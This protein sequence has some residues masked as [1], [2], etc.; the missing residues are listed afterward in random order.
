MPTPAETPLVAVYRVGAFNLETASVAQRRRARVQWGGILNRLTHPI[1]II[2][3]GRPMTTLPVVEG[4]RSHPVRAAR[5]LGAWFET[6]LTTNN[7]VD[8][9]RLLVVTRRRREGAAVPNIVRDLGDRA[10]EARALN[11]LS[12]VL[13][14]LGDLPAARARTE[15]SLAI[16]R[17]LGDQH[18]IAMS[19]INLGA[20]A[21][22]QRDY[23]RARGYLGE[24]LSIKR[25]LGDTWGLAI[26]LRNLANVAF[27]QGDVDE[28]QASL[29][30]CLTLSQRLGVP[31][32]VASCFVGLAAIAG[33]RR[34]YQ[35][36]ARLLGAAEALREIRGTPVAV[37]ER[38]RYDRDVATAR[39]HLDPAPFEA[40]W[41]EGR[42]LAVEAAVEYALSGDEK[43]DAPPRAKPGPLSAREQEVARLI[44]RGLTN[45]EIADELVI[46][47]STVER[48]VLHIFTKLRVTNR[49]QIAAWVTGQSQA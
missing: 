37:E 28:A 6:Q 43:P 12:I 40:A 19:L 25:E 27:E 45:R 41:A 20:D 35:R 3:R 21:S 4:L 32:Q 44:A 38:W 17:E 14:D 26:G 18:G 46:T 31:V 13:A 5:D 49:T 33:K 1:K 30:E 48:H 39:A 9:D 15:E 16:R 29:E 10:E 7:L 11:N 24:S 36:A 2:V 8:R 47:T 23:V 34:G 42:A 22:F